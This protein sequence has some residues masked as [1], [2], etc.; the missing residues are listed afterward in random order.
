MGDEK[1]NRVE[2]TSEMQNSVDALEKMIQNSVDVLEEMQ[3]SVDVLAGNRVR[4]VVSW[5]FFAPNCYYPVYENIYE[6]VAEE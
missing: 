6:E 1:K 2:I 3:N 4:A 5:Q